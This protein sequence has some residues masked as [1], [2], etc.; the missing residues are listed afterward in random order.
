MVFQVLTSCT[1]LLIGGFRLL[2]ENISGMKL[3]TKGLWIQFH[4]FVAESI[5]PL[6]LF[7]LREGKHFINPYLQ[8][9]AITAKAIYINKQ[10]KSELE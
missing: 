7:Y 10:F 1:L 5:F 2:K 4:F 6:V 3:L 8:M 9:W